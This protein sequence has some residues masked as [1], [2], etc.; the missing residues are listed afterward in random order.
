MSWRPRGCCGRPVRSS[1]PEIHAALGA[2][3]V[4]YCVP[5]P[6]GR[7]D[8][9]HLRVSYA[10]YDGSRTGL[11][12]ET[13]CVQGDAV[14]ATL[15]GDQ[16]PATLVSELDRYARRYWPAPWGRCVS[17]GITHGQ[18]FGAPV[19]EYLPP[20]LVRERVALAGDAAHVA[21]P[22]TGAGFQNALLDVAA[23]AACLG[24]ADAVGVPAGLAR[25]Q[26][27]RLPL[28][29]QLVSSGMSWGRS[30]PAG[31]IGERSAEVDALRTGQ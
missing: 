17:W 28:A 13:G 5:G 10:W 3:L 7:T 20:R 19:A 23:L 2:Q 14:V 4:I 11:L 21:S 31:E 16:L 15:R 22:M 1:S 18:V 25:Y 9:G 27:E 8:R 12:R 24:G 26:H 30:Y 6:D 29:R